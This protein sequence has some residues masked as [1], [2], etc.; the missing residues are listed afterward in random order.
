MNQETSLSL[1]QQLAVLSDRAAKYR[2]Y[3]RLAMK[4]GGF[5]LMVAVVAYALGWYTE[6]VATL[7]SVHVPVSLLQQ[8]A[9][10]ADA[11]EPFTSG[12]SAVFSG[13][14]GIA[15]L[16]RMLSVPLALVIA[17][18]GVV[19]GSV[20]GMISGVMVAVG[21]MIMPGILG[22]FADAAGG[23][24]ISVGSPGKTRFESAINDKDWPVAVKELEALQ[25]HGG[26]AGQYTLA[27]LLVME[28]KPTA[29]LVHLSAVESD[30]K[31]I[32]LAEA[33]PSVLYALDVQT[34]GTVRSRQAVAYESENEK[35]A[36]AF[37]SSSR[38]FGIAGLILSVISLL[39]G[40]LGFK[41]TSRVDRIRSI[42]TSNDFEI[43]E[44][45]LP[46]K[47]EQVAAEPN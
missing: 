26:P 30:E 14:A 40:G 17:G 35:S 15:G 11:Y 5:G 39:T 18:V 12:I 29:A 23:P 8:I 21:A 9:R 7:S 4:A 31:S 27:Q 25:D 42:A 24:T 28:K 32:A 34:T 3:G 10:R 41:I 6:P 33:K 1:G 36:S 19:R 44:E 13:M 2:R 16:V 20:S 47:S 22:A 43:G 45:L 46:K 38:F 37:Y